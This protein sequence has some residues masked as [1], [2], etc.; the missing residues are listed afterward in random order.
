MPLKR[1]H[2]DVLLCIVQSIVAVLVDL[3][4]STG[5]AVSADALRAAKALQEWCVCEQN[6]ELVKDFTSE[7]LSDLQGALVFPR[8]RCPLNMEQQIFTVCFS[9][10]LLRCST[11]S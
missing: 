3:S 8:G 10:E 11:Y 6:D 4:F 5:S 1:Q 2:C 7:L 9:C